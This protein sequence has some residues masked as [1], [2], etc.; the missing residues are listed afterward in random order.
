M[1]FFLE[2]KEGEIENATCGGMVA[3]S[4]YVMVMD[5]GNGLDIY[6]DNELRCQLDYAEIAR[7]EA[8]L[9]MLD[10][11]TTKGDALLGCFKVYKGEKI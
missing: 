11:V 4:E 5:T 1:K 6:V 9:K 7:V 3:T 2:T 10:A 8:C